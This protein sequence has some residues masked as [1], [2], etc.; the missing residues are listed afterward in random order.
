MVSIAHCPDRNLRKV[1]ILL[2]AFEKQAKDV[3]YYALDVS[4]PELHR[5]FSLLDTQAYKHV[6]FH[7][8]HATYDDG[9]AWLNNDVDKDYTSTTI[10][11]LGSSIGNF[12]RDEAALFLAE[13]VK[14]LGP[15]DHLLI[16]L[17][18]C[19][20]S[21]RVFKAYND[22]QKVTESFY[23]NGL[24]HANR[25]LGSQVF[26]QQDWRTEGAYDE[27]QNRHF[28]CYVPLKDFRH[29]DISIKAGE[30]IQF[31]HSYKYSDKE[32]DSLWQ[33]ANLIHQMA[34]S[35]KDG[36]YHLHLLSPAKIEFA[37][38]ANDY[39]KG[40]IPTISEWQTLWAVWDTV[41][42]AMVPR[43]ELLEKPI[44]LRNNLIFYLGHIPAFADIHYTKATDEEPTD[45][46]NYHAIFERGIDPDVENPE[47]CNAHSE[48]PDAWP[49][50]DEILGYQTKVRSR[51]IDSYR[52]G[53]VNKDRRLSRGL[54]LAYEHEALH[55]ETFL[56]MLIQSDRIL[57]PPGKEIPD[58]KGLAIAAAKNRKAAKWHQV[59]ATDIV[60]GLDDPENNDGPDRFFGWDN[61]R[62]SRKASVPAFD[63]QSRPISNGEYA[64]FLDATNADTLPAS[65]I[66]SETNGEA[67]VGGDADLLKEVAYCKPCFPGGKGYQD[68]VWLSPSQVCSG[69]A[70]DGIVQ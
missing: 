25:L 56:Y 9:L 59:P 4:L 41:T 64:Q 32:S 11:S 46:A 44:K 45:P 24:T 49:P 5:T 51:I 39:A 23:R 12:T 43:E 1:S 48:I 17:D 21:H 66:S 30:K 70:S 42:R 18:A 34:F 60:L 38:K 20:D 29:Q 62:P 58:F 63:A 67:H 19:Q 16:G 55:L 53:K 54:W 26:N 50:L 13:F 57:P 33:S 65:W 47:I 14:V 10:M 68:C 15:A 52:S 7:G 35:N 2:D 28:A 6:S 40:P 37:E 31:E 61:E 8:L 22:S 27:Q 3:K 69:L 36:D